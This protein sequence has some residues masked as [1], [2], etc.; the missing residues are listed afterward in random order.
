M[1]CIVISPIEID[2]KRVEVGETRNLTASEY[3]RLSALGCV[4]LKSAADKIAAAE[5][6]AEAEIAAAHEKAAEE[7]AEERAKA[8]AEAD[9]LRAEAEAK[10]AAERSSKGRGR[11]RRAS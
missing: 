10:A 11:G 9:K 2:G 6:K 7:V 8:E 4:E 1:H 3:A 5:A